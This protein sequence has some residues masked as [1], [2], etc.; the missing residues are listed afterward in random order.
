MGHG[1]EGTDGARWAFTERPLYAGHSQGAHYSHNTHPLSSSLYGQL[2][3]LSSFLLCIAGFVFCSLKLSPMVVLS[4][5]Y[6]A[7][8]GELRWSMKSAPSARPQSFLQQARPGL[9]DLIHH[10]TVSIARINSFLYVFLDQSHQTC[11]FDNFQFTDWMWDLILGSRF[12]MRF[13]IGIQSS[14]SAPTLCCG[15]W[16]LFSAS[17]WDFALNDTQ[18]MIS[19][20]AA[21]L[22]VLFWQ[23]FSRNK[24]RPCCMFCQKTSFVVFVFQGCWAAPR[25]QIF[26][27]KTNPVKNVSWFYFVAASIKR[28]I[29][30]GH[31]RA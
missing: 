5:W 16:S 21:M 22:A 23:K 9:T 1:Q 26:E 30:H 20:C 15:S 13:W 31:P 4:S 8:L 6:L 27:L 28:S 17:E 11:S 7:V 12:W 14:Y 10:C 2:P 18:R 29:D 3:S 24:S 25:G 19:C